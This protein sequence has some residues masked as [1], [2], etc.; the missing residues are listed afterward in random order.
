MQVQVQCARV[1]R[2]S[3]S[4]DKVEQFRARPLKWMT[5]KRRGSVISGGGK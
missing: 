3:S 4:A 2:E 1:G 5:A